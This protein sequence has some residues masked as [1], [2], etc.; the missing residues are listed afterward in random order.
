[1]NC[2][3]CNAELFVDRMDGDGKFWYACLNPACPDFRRAF[4]PSTG[5]VTEASIKAKDTPRV[6]YENTNDAE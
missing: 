1:M 6:I 2:P 4:Q 3:K 5:D